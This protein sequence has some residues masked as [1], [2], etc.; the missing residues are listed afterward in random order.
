MLNQQ[1]SEHVNSQRML[2]TKLSKVI[3]KCKEM[4]TE[5][6]LLKNNYE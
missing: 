6:D 1:I 2:E 5:Y 3:E 4:K